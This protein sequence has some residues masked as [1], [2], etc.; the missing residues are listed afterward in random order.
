[1]FVKRT[2]APGA[3]HLREV[4]VEAMAPL[5]DPKRLD[6]YFKLLNLRESDLTRRAALKGIADLKDPNASDPVVAWLKKEPSPAVRREAITTLGAI[7]GTDQFQTLY[8]SMQPANESDASVREEAWRVFASLLPD[9]STAQ[10]NR[11][12]S[13]FTFDSDKLVVV[14]KALADKLDQDKNYNELAKT[15]QS[16]GEALM[17]TTPPQPTEA[18]K[19]FR[20]SL[21]YFQKNNNPQMVIE[22][23]IHSLL[24]ALLKS[25][26]YQEAADF[27]SKMIAT[28]PENQLTVGPM[29]KEEAE[30]LRD[31][32][33]FQDAQRLIDVTKKMQPALESRYAKMLVEIEQD[34][35]RRIATQ[36]EKNSGAA[37]RINPGL[38]AG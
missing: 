12:P 19:Y 36:N 26:Q 6:T 38:L 27:A 33:Q 11:W 13:Q 30:H 24:E 21:D 9:A 29:F 28:S 10:V 32:N 7:G 17:K 1:V 31:N 20:L 4:L 22:T 25:K 14:L 5:R 37:P 8:Q 3:E 34:V 15:R 16:I 23:N 2:D 35:Q 18:A